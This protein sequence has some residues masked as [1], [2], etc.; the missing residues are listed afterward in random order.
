MH[1]TGVRKIQKFRYD[2]ATSSSNLV[3]THVLTRQLAEVK[4]IIVY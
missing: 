4:D 3:M 2:E 1:C